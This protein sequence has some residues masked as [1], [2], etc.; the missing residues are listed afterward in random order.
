MLGTKYG[1][2]DPTNSTG[3]YYCDVVLDCF[4]DMIT[5]MGKILFFDGNEEQRHEFLQQ[6]IEKLHKP[7]LNFFEK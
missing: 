3:I 4:S 6:E 1:F 7:A 5:S 2:Y